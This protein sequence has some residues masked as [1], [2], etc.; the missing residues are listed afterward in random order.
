MFDNAIKNGA[1]Y[2][3]EI[4]ERT[5]AGRAGEAFLRS[6]VAGLHKVGRIRP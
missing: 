6:R 4:R 2:V 5:N 3:D 1:D